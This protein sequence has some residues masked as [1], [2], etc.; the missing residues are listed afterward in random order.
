MFAHSLLAR[1]HRIFE[2]A[3][4][5]TAK[6]LMQSKDDKTSLI[7]ITVKQ[8]TSIKSHLLK[9]VGKADLILRMLVAT[10]GVGLVLC[11]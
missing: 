6:H 3:D 1:E 11:L 4:V 2:L 9:T 8:I 5:T 7:K 10:E